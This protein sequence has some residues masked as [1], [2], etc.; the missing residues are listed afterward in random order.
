MQSLDDPP[1]P[2]A[3][4]TS[5]NTLQAKLAAE[6]LNVAASNAFDLIRTLR[7]CVLLLDEEAI[8]AEEECEALDVM[9]A[10]LEAEEE[11]VELES[12]L[13]EMRNGDILNHNTK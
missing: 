5:L 3:A 2:L 13:V 4:S 9:E 7:L 10:R 1:P 12:R 11:C 8:R 6:N